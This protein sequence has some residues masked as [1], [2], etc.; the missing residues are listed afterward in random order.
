[1]KQIYDSGNNYLVVPKLFGKGGYWKTF[2]WNAASE[3]GMKSVDLAYS[4][5]FDFIETEMYWPINHMVVG[6]D[7]ALS[8]TACHGKKGTKR[9]D[10]TK[11]GYDGDPLKSGSRFE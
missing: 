10:W 3:L 6:G 7:Q 2:D 4:G 5:K 8:C 9:L 11:L 1:G